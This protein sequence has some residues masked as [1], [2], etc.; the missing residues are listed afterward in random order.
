M[1]EEAGM[2][3]SFTFKQTISA[4]SIA[5]ALLFQ[6]MGCSQH[7]MAITGKRYTETGGPLFPSK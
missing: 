2:A 5:I 7:T 6:G 3:H 1:S 4:L